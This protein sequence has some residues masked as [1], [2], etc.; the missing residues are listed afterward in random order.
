M[1]H[2]T[3]FKSHVMGD[4]DTF[5]VRKCKLNVYGRSLQRWRLYN[6]VTVRSEAGN[7]RS[8]QMKV[9]SRSFSVTWQAAG[10]CFF[11]GGFFYE[12]KRDW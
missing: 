5:T 6:V 3:G 9:I 10:F 12:K 8:G 11:V 4:L 7:F 1:F 2:I